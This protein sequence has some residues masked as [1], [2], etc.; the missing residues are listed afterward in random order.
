[1]FCNLEIWEI[2]VQRINGFLK[3][4]FVYFFLFPKHSPIFTDFLK[5][6]V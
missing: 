1:M 4:V 2:F 3:K 5:I 6:E